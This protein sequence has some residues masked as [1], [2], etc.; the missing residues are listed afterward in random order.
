MRPPALLSRI[1]RTITALSG[2]D[3]RMIE[4][5]RSNL[6]VAAPGAREPDDVAALT[7]GLIVRDGAVQPAGPAGYGADPALA[8]AALTAIRFEPEVRAAASLRPIPA[9]AEALDAHLRELA[10]VD[11]RRTPPGVSTMDWAIAHASKEGVP[12]AVLVEGEVLLLFAAT[13]EE[14]VDEIIMLSSHAII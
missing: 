1:D 6:A 3:V 13:I 14:T 9:L 12:D 8:R 4:P 5:G 7:G 10:R 11:P 2:I